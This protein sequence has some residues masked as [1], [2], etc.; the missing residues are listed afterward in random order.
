ME[1]R[2]S[3]EVLAAEIIEKLK[4][5]KYAYNTIC[6]FRASFNRI[7]VFAR[8]R[9]EVYFSEEFGKEYLEKKCGCTTDYY[10]EAFPR[11]AKQA[12]R[13]IR[14]IGDY[15]L[16]GVIIRRIVK[17]KGYVKPPQFEEILTAYQ[18]GMRR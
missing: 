2:K 16:H 17:R 7:C 11:K 15:Q 5:L 12:I 9:D 14:L 6:G 4:Q 8:D 18:E 3:I 10:L 1:K 13:S